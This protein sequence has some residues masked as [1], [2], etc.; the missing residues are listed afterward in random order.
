[1]KKFY[2][3]LCTALL[4]IVFPAVLRAATVN[5]VIDDPTRVFVEMNYTPVEGLVAGSNTIDVPEYTPVYIKA[6]DGSF[7]LSV[8]RES[9]A[10]NEY[11]YSFTSC[12]LSISTDETFTVTSALADDVRDASCTI[13]VDHAADVVVQR[14]G[15]YTNVNLVDGENTVKFM[16]DQET[17]L[18]I[19]PAVYGNSLYKV[20]LNGE[21]Q[22]AQNGQYYL[23]IKD[24]DK[25]EILSEF[26]DITC[27]VSF[28]YANDESKEFFSAVKLNGE[29]VE[30]FNDGFNAKAGQSVQLNGRINDFKLNDFSINGTHLSM[31]SDYSFTVTE[32]TE[33]FVDATKYGVVNAYFTIDNPEAITLYRGYVYNND[34]LP[35]TAGENEVELSSN[36]CVLQV[37]PTNDYYITSIKANDLTPDMDYNGAYTINVVEGM[38]INVE[39]AAVVRDQTAMLYVDDATLPYYLC[40]TPSRGQ[41]II[42]NSGN[43]E[44]QF[45]EAENPFTL[46]YYGSPVGLVYVNGEKVSPAYEGGSYYTF[47][48][49]DKDAVRMYFAAEPASYNVTFTVN[50]DFT[51]EFSVLTDNIHPESAWAEGLKVLDGTRLAVVPGAGSS[52]KVFI[53]DTEV[54]A[55]NGEYATEITADTQIRVENGVPVGINHITETQNNTVYSLDGRRMNNRNLHSGIYVKNGKKVIVD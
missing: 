7:L 17:M 49:K 33:I 13:T 37:M 36:N 30:N 38:K 6:N 42:L 39:T 47:S 44:L 55:V 28:S 3:F 22:M 25:L 41:E 23:G 18:Y 9:T 1:M 4:G 8:V 5:I 15:T 10:S 48:L 26:P 45:S 14:T 52:I 32:D 29:D 27:A 43:T 46:S 19:Y 12:Y 51:G 16:S 24:G 50:D 53:N 31:W 34:T 21:S 40:F 11:I 35:L 54:E 20:T 2:V